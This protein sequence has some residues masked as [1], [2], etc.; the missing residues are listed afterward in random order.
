M[1]CAEPI[2]LLQRMGVYVGS[3]AQAN[4][5][6]TARPVSPYLGRVRKVHVRHG[7]LLNVETNNN[8]EGTYHDSEFDDNAVVQSN[9]VAG[10]VQDAMEKHSYVTYKPW[11]WEDLHAS[12]TARRRC[13]LCSFQGSI[14]LFQLLYYRV[15]ISATT[16]NQGPPHMLSD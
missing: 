10:S 6:G 1:D 12:A 3:D 16:C 5:G 11:S 4:L 2:G 14:F 15:V 8:S 13:H 7:S 9:S